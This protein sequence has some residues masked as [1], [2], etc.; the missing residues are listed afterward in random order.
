MLNGE[1]YKRWK[2][3]VCLDTTL[4]QL[5]MSVSTR[6]QGAPVTIQP[7]K[8]ARKFVTYLRFDVTLT[9]TW[10]TSPLIPG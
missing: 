9:K 5:G 1:W 3:D 6:E 4:L 7:Q 10:Q 8:N 2:A